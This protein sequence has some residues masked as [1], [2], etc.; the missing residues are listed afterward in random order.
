MINTALQLKINICVA[1]DCSSASFFELTKT[2]VN[3]TNLTGWGAPNP[4][5]GEIEHVS[6]TITNPT[7]QLYTFSYS[8]SYLLPNTFPTVDEDL[9]FLIPANE[10]GGTSK[11]TSGIWKA[12]YQVDNNDGSGDPQIFSESVERYFLVYCKW[13]SCVDK[14]FTLVDPLDDCGCHDSTESSLDAYIRAKTALDQLKNAVKCNNIA[15]ALLII[16][17]LDYLCSQTNCGC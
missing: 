6:L 4:L 2:Y 13:Q 7:G 11:L 14:L 3:P 17:Y 12:K 1:R 8:S 5:I 10:L 16:E 9:E 15:D